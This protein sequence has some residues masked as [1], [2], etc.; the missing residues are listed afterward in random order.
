[1]CRQAEQNN[2]KSSTFQ[3]FAVG[4]CWQTVKGLILPT[5]HLNLVYR[6]QNVLVLHIPLH[7][8]FIARNWFSSGN[9]QLLYK[10]STRG[11]EFRRKLPAPE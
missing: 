4:M 9:Y 3:Q 8:N 10:E 11:M 7:K 5:H 6:I 1:M 2:L